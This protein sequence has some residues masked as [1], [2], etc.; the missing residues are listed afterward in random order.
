MSAFDTGK[1]TIVPGETPGQNDIGWLSYNGKPVWNN[2]AEFSTGAAFDS[3]ADVPNGIVGPVWVAGKQYLSNG[4]TIVPSG[5]N[6]KLSQTPGVVRLAT[7]GDSTARVS[8]AGNFDFT[9]Y[10]TTFPVSGTTSVD[11]RDTT[12]N[13]GHLP[14]VKIVGDGG[15]AGETT[16]QMLDRS[17]AD[18]SSTRKSIE[19][20][21]STK[22]DVVYLSAGSIND[23]ADIS[24]ANYASK[25]A[26]TY[27]NH[28]KIL[29][30]F[31]NSGIFVVDVGVLGYSA[32]SG[33][34]DLKKSALLEL[35]AMYDIYHKNLDDT[36]F[37]NL[38]DVLHDSTG[39]YFP[40]ISS[41]GTHLMVGGSVA[42]GNIIDKVIS[43]I[44]STRQNRYVGINVFNNPD[45]EELDEPLAYGNRATGITI[46]T[47]N[48][49][50]VNADVIRR[51]GKMWQ[52]CDFDITA[53][54]AYGWIYKAIDP[55]LIVIAAND[56]FGFE[57]DYYVEVVGEK[58]NVGNIQVR[59][60]FTQLSPAANYLLYYANAGDDYD[61]NLSVLEGRA[62]FPDLTVLNDGSNLTNASKIG[63]RVYSNA[64]GK[65]LRLG[66]SAPKM[67]KL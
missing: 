18:A 37:I 50:R 25:I 1:K 34:Y 24:S 20:I 45:F 48:A 59:L 32:T 43:S 10:L 65:T 57:F 47:T 14:Y 42:V 58:L 15:V 22:P 13:C 55:S 9:S 60:E 23:L 27:E 2:G 38:I 49:T 64:V 21:I 7:F 17:L 46:L 41:D 5:S 28:L 4:V 61:A 39:S 35:N 3:L 67:I 11:L 52:F 8:T 30:R 36:Y 6:I 53:S 62:V 66:M 16:Q 26:T 12:V 31:L 40:G 29:T 19:D 56:I 51:N 63:I 54:S 44:F 33:E